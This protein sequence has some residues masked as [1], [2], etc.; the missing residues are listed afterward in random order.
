MLST[1]IRQI[2]TTNNTIYYLN[3]KIEKKLSYDY[4]FF[5]TDPITPSKILGDKPLTKDLEKK[6]WTGTSG[7]ITLFFKN[8]V[9][10]TSKSRSALTIF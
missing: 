5:A 10:Y 9:K 1:E 2:D 3:D 4:I 8:P 7:K 6:D